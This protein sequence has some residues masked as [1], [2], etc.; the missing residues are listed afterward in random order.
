MTRSTD[1]RRAR[2]SASLT[3]G[4]RR[5]PASRPSRRRCFFGLEAGGAGDRGD[6][7][8]GRAGLADPGDG[9]LR[10]VPALVAVLA[11]AAA[12]ATTARRGALVVALVVVASSAAVA[13]A[14]RPGCRPGGCPDDRS[15][16]PAGGCRTSRPGRRRPLRRRSRSRESPPSP[17]PG[18]RRRR[19]PR[20]RRRRG[21]PSDSSSSCCS[22]SSDS[23][24]WAASAAPAC[25]PGR[26]SWRSAC[27]GT[28]A[29]AHLRLGVVGGGGFGLVALSVVALSR[30]GRLL[31]GGLLRSRLL[32]GGLLGRCLRRGGL[33]DLEEGDDAGRGGRSL[34]GG[35]VGRL[36]AGGGSRGDLLRRLLRRGPLGGGLLGRRLLRGGLLGRGGLGRR[37]GGR[38][39]SLGSLGRGSRGL[40]GGL[41]RRGPLGGGLLGRR[42]LRGLRGRGG[43]VTGVGRGGVGL[44]VVEQDVLLGPGASRTGRFV[45]RRPEWAEPTAKSL[46]VAAASSAVRRRGWSTT[47]RGRRAVQSEDCGGALSP[48]PPGRVA[49]W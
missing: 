24:D 6:L 2:N 39:R 30:G 36:G 31:G 40:L 3:I 16:C 9:V 32:G 12:T 33:G 45:R 18:L 49:V 13:G 5:R 15:G 25:R 42:L 47:C 37:L 46:R 8:L 41:L 34:R 29:R 20:R 14:R 4:A 22:V 1:S 27:P 43:P 10:V 44:V 28:G 48:D 35:G 23:P 21:P 26:P 17:S 7:V 38:L 19:P 11:G